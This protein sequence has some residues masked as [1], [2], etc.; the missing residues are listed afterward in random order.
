[1]I[2]SLAKA[3]EMIPKTWLSSKNAVV[4]TFYINPRLPLLYIKWIFLSV[5]TRLRWLE[6]FKN[7]FSFPRLD[8]PK[9]QIF[10]ILW[11]KEPLHSPILFECMGWIKMKG[12]M[13]RFYR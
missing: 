9:T 12:R 4:D 7:S 11:V 13:K 5:S 10:F 8:T 2:F 3:F 1:V 6:D